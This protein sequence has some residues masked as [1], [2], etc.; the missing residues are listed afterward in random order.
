MEGVE[1]RSEVGVS[2]GV[3]VADDSPLLLELWWEWLLRFTP[4]TMIGRATTSSEAEGLGADARVDLLVL[5][6]SLAGE[7]FEVVRALRWVRPDIVIVVLSGEID[8]E[9]ALAAGADFAFDKADGPRVL[10]DAVGLATR[11][12]MGIE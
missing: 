4:V 1:L 8:T 9:G 7:H 5:D 10:S 2:I 12:V 3:G 11:R 6:Q